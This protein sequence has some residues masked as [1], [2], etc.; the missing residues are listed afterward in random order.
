[1]DEM[2]TVKRCLVLGLGK[3][4]DF[5]PDG[6]TKSITGCKMFYIGTDDIN[7]SSVDDESG[8]IGYIPQKVTMEPAFYETTKNVPLPCLADITFAI[9]LETS[10]AKVRVA[11]VDFVQPSKK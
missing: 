7:K 2:K 8:A 10:G 6:E 11:G 5:I 9:K 1:M 3:P 4:Y